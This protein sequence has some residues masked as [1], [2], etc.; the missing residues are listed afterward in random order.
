MIIFELNDKPTISNTNNNYSSHNHTFLAT[1]T[2]TSKTTQAKS[3][4]IFDTNSSKIDPTNIF[5]NTSALNFDRNDY[6]VIC[7]WNACHL[8]NKTH[9][10]SDFIRSSDPDIICLNEHF[11]NEQEAN[12]T[13]SGFVNFNTIYSFRSDRTGGGTAIMIK[14]NLPQTLAHKHCLREQRPGSSSSHNRNNQFQLHSR[15]LLQPTRCDSQR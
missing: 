1:Q 2:K 5:Y 8:S 13:F 15:E 3:Q 11:L 4:N 12:Y 7:H 9:M 6:L 10:L 14:K